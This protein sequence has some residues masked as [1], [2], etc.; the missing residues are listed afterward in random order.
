M[1]KETSCKLLDTMQ[2]NKRNAYLISSNIAQ[3]VIDNAADVLFEGAPGHRSLAHN[4]LTCP[5]FFLTRRA[6]L[7]R[8]GPLLQPLARPSRL[9]S[10]L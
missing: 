9:L 10:F 2:E 3:G 6:D 5:M 7:N 4:Q 8:V 1:S